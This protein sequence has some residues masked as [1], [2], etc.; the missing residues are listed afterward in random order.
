MIIY[1][2]HGKLGTPDGTKIK[3]LTKVA[4]RQGHSVRNIDYTD[5]LD[6]DVRAER[7]SSILKNDAGRKILV[8]SSMGGYASLVASETI[9]VKGVFL[10]APALYLDG[11][12][13]QKFTPRAEFIE[14]V[15]GWN[16]M[17]IPFEN[18]IRFAKKHRATLH[19]LDSDHRLYSALEKI[20]YF[21]KHFL[22]N[23]AQD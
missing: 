7:L 20:E 1:F 19:I 13:V 2:S 9:P 15:H 4:Q 11:Y 10:L 6:P 14:I 8:G 16:D 21:F 17:T 5:T 18:S 3:R 23:I 22:I 12:K